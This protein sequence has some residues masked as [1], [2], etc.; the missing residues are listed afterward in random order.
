M[1]LKLVGDIKRGGIQILG[2]EFKVAT[3]CVRGVISEIWHGK[4]KSLYRYRIDDM[5][6]IVEYLAL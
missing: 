1:I 6:I 2:G 3:I 4:W 5:V